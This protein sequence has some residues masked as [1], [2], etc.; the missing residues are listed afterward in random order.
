MRILF[1]YQAFEIQKIGGVSRLYAEIIPCLQDLG[2]QCTLG[3]KESDNVYIKHD[4]IKPLNYT[5]N[6]YFNG[7]KWFKGQ[8][9]LTRKIMQVAGHKRDC[10]NINQEYCIKLLKQQQFDIFEPS[11]FDDYF[12]SYLK[13]KPF[14][15]EVHDMIPELFSQYFPRDNFQIIKKKKL[16]PLATAIH[17][18][19]LKTK[20][21]LVNILNIEP[22]KITVI[23][24]GTPSINIPAIESP[25][26]IDKPY[27]L[28]VGERGGYKNF[29]ALL[30]E[31]TIL[32]QSVPELNLL[33]TGRPFDNDECQLLYNLGLSNHVHQCF[34][35]DDNF[36]ALYHH[37]LAFVYP[38][39]YEGFGLP[40]LEAYACG[41][42]VLLN[43]ASC[44]P[45]IGG[46][47]AIYF[48]IDQKGDLAE[49]ILNLL[50]CGNEER[51]Q[52]ITR[53]KKRAQCFSWQESARKLMNVYKTIL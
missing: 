19:S 16:C 27:L 24:R 13:G 4:G 26:L 12:L 43:N 22:D 38:S 6:K 50:H 7:K 41:C 35:N 1:D 17:V 28:Y 49:H 39:A 34:A 44:F 11:F 30:H 33:C 37:A 40:I 3:L 23:G 14:S 21:D 31:M 36:Y 51:R 42:P 32:I 29:T 53:G 45:E 25:R 46:E 10:L 15:M 48:N 2:V 8:R 18:P 20:E 5:H 9:T 47:A 52:I